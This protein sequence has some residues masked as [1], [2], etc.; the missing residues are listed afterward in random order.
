MISER[1]AAQVRTMLTGVVEAGGTAAQAAIDGYTLAGKTGT[2]NKIDRRTGEYST[3]RYIASFVGFAPV[4]DPKLLVTIMVDEPQGA[5]YG[6][7]VA[8]PAFQEITSFALAYLRI[9]PS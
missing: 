4:R 6:A 5:I 3:T 2:A 8:A 9:A 1:T 7:E